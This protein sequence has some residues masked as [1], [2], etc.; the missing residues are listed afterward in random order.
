MKRMS[1]NMMMMMMQM[2]M[3][4]CMCMPQRAHNGHMLSHIC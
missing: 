2:C 3:P 1:V 4:M